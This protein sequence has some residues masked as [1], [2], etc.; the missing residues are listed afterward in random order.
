MHNCVEKSLV[1]KLLTINHLNSKNFSSL[2]QIFCKEWFVKKVKE[3]K[4]TL[5]KDKVCLREEIR[6]IINRNPSQWWREFKQALEE[7][8]DGRI[9]G[10]IWKES[11]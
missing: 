6:G 10:A 4:N 5:L 8:G 1:F 11:D 7:V 2:N 3:K 9:V